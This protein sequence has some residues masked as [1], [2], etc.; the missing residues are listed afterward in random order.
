MKTLRGLLA[1][2]GL[3]T[4]AALAAAL[5]LLFGVNVLGDRALRNARVDL[6]ENGLYTLSDGSR[7]LLRSLAEPVTL[8]L[9]L[10]RSLAT[11]LPGINAYASRVEELLEEFRRESNGGVRLEVIDPEPFSEAEDQALAYGLEG[12]PLGDAEGVFYFG[13]AASGP[14]D[15]EE[16]IP[17]FSGARENFLEYDLSRLI[18]QVS[19]AR[20]TRVGLLTTLPMDGSGP[21]VQFTGGGRPWV[22]LEQIEQFF[23]VESIAPDAARIPDG[24]DV[25]MVVHPS[26]LEPPALYAIDQFVLGGGKAMIF[27]DPYAEGDRATLFGG[28]A[29]PAGHA[30]DDLL[31]AWGLRLRPGAVAADINLASRVQAQVQGRN[32]VVDYPVWMTVTPGQF[33]REDAITA[34]LGDVLMATAGVLESVEASGLVVSPLATTTDSAT[35]VDPALLGPAGDPVALLR[36]Y[37]ADGERLML[38]ARVSGA[39]QSAYAGRPARAG[40]GAE[41]PDRDAEGPD[42]HAHRAQSSGPVHVIVVAD[43]DLLRDRFWVGT[44]RILGSTL[45]IP[46]A[47]NATLVINALENLAGGPSL[48][49]IRSRGSHARPFTLLEDVRRAAEIEFRQKEQELLNELDAA[50]ARL[51]ELQRREAN[52]EGLILSD[53]Q[54]RELERFRQR[55]VH[56]RKELREVRRSLREDL[57]GIQSWVKF[58]NIGLM[59]LL[60]GCGGLLFGMRR[61]AARSR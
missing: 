32:V 15:E 27:V 22:I 40:S 7:E 59:P 50:E 28:G 16:I 46:T 11:R 26:N 25:L 4:C 10:S 61:M 44:Q 56:I 5:A 8:R 24:I 6:T 17:F 39:A 30:F 52:G 55:K 38:A 49:G 14:A 42:S 45:W 37:R 35:T 34:E 18:F 51:A 29:L 36:N 53:E 43:T 12:V 1:N 48:I 54:A 23:Q 47:A 31:R 2:T 21:E 19:A 41:P 58:V 20:E 57:E 13:L 3:Y 33:D 9:F 60:V